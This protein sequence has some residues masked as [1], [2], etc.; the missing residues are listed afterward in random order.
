MKKLS[1][2]FI[3]IILIAVFA[4]G[5]SACN[6]KGSSIDLSANISYAETHKYVGE[7]EN[8]KVSVT[9]GIREQMFIA[10]GVA[11]NVAEFATVSVMPQKSDLLTK[12]YTYALTADGG[13]FSG[14]L[15]RD[16]VTH[17][18][19]ASVELSN[20]KD[21]L[22]NLKIYYDSNEVE[23]PLENKMTGKISYMQA[24]DIAIT[25]FRQLI[26]AN[27]TDNVLPREIIVK[28]IRDKR[29]PDSPYFWYVS[30]IAADSNYWA[31]LL[32][33][34]SGEVVTKKQ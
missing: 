20:L 15:E 12:E 9:A 3:T 30:F 7:D 21:S 34:V 6:K 23:I 17:A 26:D 33:P 24:L 32:D 31:I 13:E 29:N 16:P 27:L 8:F 28:L 1:L 2:T 19:V 4:V 25:E 10:D 22:Q 11:T 5:F 18:F 14:T